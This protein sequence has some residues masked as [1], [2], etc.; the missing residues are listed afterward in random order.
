MQFVLHTSSSERSSAFTVSHTCALTALL[1][2]ATE[3][4]AA[5]TALPEIAQT[6]FD[7]LPAAVRSAL[8]I[9]PALKDVIFEDKNGPTLNSILNPI[10]EHKL[11]FVGAGVQVANALEVALKL[12][13]TCYV[14]CEGFEVEQFLH[15]PFCSTDESTLVVLLDGGVGN[16]RRHE[17]LL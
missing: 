1:V 8:S 16:K 3:I 15:G 17:R 9:E 13:E 14:N 12:K 11:Y 7:A 6:N 5:S 10:R 2:L 4:A